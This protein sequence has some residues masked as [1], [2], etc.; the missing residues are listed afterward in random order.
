MKTWVKFGLIGAMS[1]CAA[2][3]STFD[4]VLTEDGHEERVGSGAMVNGQVNNAGYLALDDASWGLAMNL[5]GLAAGSHAL[6]NKSGTLA[7][8]R[9]GTGEVFTTDLGGSCTVWLNPHQSTN[10]SA[11]TGWFYCSAVTSNTGRK[12]D[13]GSGEFRTLINDAGNNPHLNGPP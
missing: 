5:Q 12:V 4:F 8:M 3:R 9:K 6:S 11:V 7:I 13:V 10:G 1:A 2:P